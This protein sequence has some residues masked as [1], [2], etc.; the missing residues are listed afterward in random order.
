MKP[1][2]NASIAAVLDGASAA[3]LVQH[4]LRRRILAAARTPVSATGLAQ[5]FGQPRQRVNYHVRQL[6]R[7]GYLLPAGRRMK[8]NLEERRYVASARAYVLAPQL[9][10]DV[11]ATPEAAGDVL[12]AAHLL[13]LATLAQCEL[14]E[15]TEAAARAGVRVLTLSINSELRFG[16]AEQRAAFGR[17]LTEAV[18][19]AIARHTVAAHPAA[20]EAP[21]VRY[22]LVLG[23]YPIPARSQ[24]EE[25]GA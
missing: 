4:P 25:E 18:T 16:S 21:G 3:I 14:V 24:P 17:A 15:V 23:C 8:R 7:A 2:P 5:Q 1:R 11:A 13:G 19:D 6:V 12:S 9:L 10:G 20:G 22:R